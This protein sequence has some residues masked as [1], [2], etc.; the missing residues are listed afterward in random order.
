MGG[1]IPFEL[2]LH[3]IYEDTYKSQRNLSVLHVLLAGRL[4]GAHSRRQSRNTLEW[5]QNFEFTVEDEGA[6]FFMTVR[7]A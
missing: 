6:E 4:V 7:D 2:P 5:N 1:V 3:I